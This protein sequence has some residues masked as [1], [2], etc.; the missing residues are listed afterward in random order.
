MRR[1]LSEQDRCLWRDSRG[2]GDD[3]DSDVR[4]LRGDERGGR[5]GGEESQNDDAGRAAD[6]GAPEGLRRSGAARPATVGRRSRSPARRQ[7]MMY[8]LVMSAIVGTPPP[9]GV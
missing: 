1:G 5:D 9:G 7:Y 2:V 6:M 3:A 8:D 4:P